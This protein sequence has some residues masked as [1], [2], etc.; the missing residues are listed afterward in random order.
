MAEAAG[1]DGS[2]TWSGCRE[3]RA[4]RTEPWGTLSFMSH[5][6]EKL[7]IVIAKTKP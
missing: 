4:F 1:V 3:R 7:A 2:D 6:E 5:G